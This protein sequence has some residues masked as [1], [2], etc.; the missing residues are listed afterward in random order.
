MLLTVAK[1]GLV[2]FSNKL[3]VVEM[4]EDAIIIEKVKDTLKG[5]IGHTYYD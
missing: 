2:I 5:Y 3:G 4:T 1:P